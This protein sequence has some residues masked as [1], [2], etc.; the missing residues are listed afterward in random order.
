[1]I[2]FK[3]LKRY[4]QGRGVPPDDFLNTLLAWGMMA[5]QDIFAAHESPNDVMNEL[6]KLL[7]PWQGDPGSADW[8]FHRRAAMLELLRCLGGFE[9]S[10]KWTCG[11]DTT[12][13]HSLANIT[14]QETGIFQVSEDSEGFSPSLR[15]CV[16]RYCGAND[17]HL[18]IDKMKTDHVFA[19]EYAARLLR[20][21]YKWDGPIKRGEIDSSISREAVEEWKVLLNS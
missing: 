1:M 2:P 6:V 14:G 21:S 11:V 10:W 8:L 17:I 13:A 15:D 3:E 4:V 18:F 19:L 5:P 12:N 9:S 7:G 16:I 20:F